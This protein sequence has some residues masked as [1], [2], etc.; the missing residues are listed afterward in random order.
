VVSQ[1]GDPQ[2][3][4]V[5]D[6]RLLGRHFELIAKRARERLVRAVAE[7]ERERENI[8]RSGGQRSRRFAASAANARD[9]KR[10]R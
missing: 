6:S 10:C 2:R 8:E 3:S 7:L 4:A 9:R 1:S 5:L